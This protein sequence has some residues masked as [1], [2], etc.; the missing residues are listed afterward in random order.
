MENTIDDL[1]FLLGYEKKPKVNSVFTMIRVRAEQDWYD[2]K[3]AKDN[4]YKEGTLQN[5]TWYK[6]WLECNK[7]A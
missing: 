7:N 6:T 1:M 2:G 3:H 4:P 5:E